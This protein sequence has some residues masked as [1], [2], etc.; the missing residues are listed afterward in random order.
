M[1]ELKFYASGKLMLFGEY[2]VLRGSK[3]LSVPLAAGQ[4]LIIRANT[5]EDI[6]W[7]CFEGDN[8]WLDILFSNTL[9]IISTSDKDKA[10]VVQKLLKFILKERPPLKMSGKS[11]RFDINF[12]R[13]YGFGTSATFISLL[14][15]WSGIDPYLLLEKSFGGSGFDVATAT[16][17]TPLVYQMKERSIKPVIIPEAIQ[18]QLLFIYSGKKQ[19]SAKEVLSFVKMHTSENQ[20][21]Q[22]NTIV[23]S[24]VGCED[25]GTLESLMEESEILLS[26]ILHA[27]PVKKMY[28]DD[29]PFAIKSLGAWGGDFIMATFRDED[30]ARQYFSEKDCKPIFNYKQLILL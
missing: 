3:C 1:N 5:S 12:H 13:K 10:S 17:G 15:Q 27:I 4:S 8:K 29:Y 2:L 7:E 23:D 26:G 30:A 6:L 14:S 11:F 9:E 22:M 24:V 21:S 19:H 16:S 20:I 28:F 18:Q 25:I